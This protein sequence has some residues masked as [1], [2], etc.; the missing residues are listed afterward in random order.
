MPDLPLPEDT[1]R[2]GLVPRLIEGGRS[3][4]GGW[5]LIGFLALVALA[6]AAFALVAPQRPSALGRPELEVQTVPVEIVDLT[7]APERLRLLSSSGARAWN[8]ALPFSTAPNAPAEPFVAPSADLQSYGRALDCLTA[9]LYYEAGSESVGGQAAVAQVVLNRV[10]HPAYPRT[11]CGVVFQGSE[12]ASGCQFTFTCDGSLRRR[13]SP[14]GWARARSVATAALT[15]RVMASVGTATHYHADWVAP[16]WA[17]RLAKVVQVQSHI[18]YRWTGAWG[19][20]RAFS[21]LYRGTEPEIAAMSGLA[22]RFPGEAASVEPAAI[23]PLP[24]HTEILTAAPTEGHVQAPTA[25]LPDKAAETLP[26]PEMEA[27]RGS[28]PGARSSPSPTL[29]SIPAQARP[30]LS[31][32]GGASRRPRRGEVYFGFFSAQLSRGRRGTP[33]A[34]PA[35]P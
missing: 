5:S 32:P 31:S 1:G 22:T 28:P 19:L 17:A 10:R 33:Q 7:V 24:P 35:M 20:P 4:I 9:A 23:E 26:G 34:S 2:R 12:R 25:A 21:G 27:R 6:V 11:V 8:A 16:L 13:P 14:A 18:F 30:W 15:G 29:W 3:E